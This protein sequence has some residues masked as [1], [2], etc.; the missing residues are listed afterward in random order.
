MADGSRNIGLAKV[1]TGWTGTLSVQVGATLVPITPSE[2]TSAIELAMRVDIVLSALGAQPVGVRADG[3]VLSWSAG[4]SFTL[5]ATGV[6]QSRL[7][8]AASTTGTTVTGAGAHADGFYP[9]QG[10]LVR[11]P[12]FA[13][14]TASPMSDGSAAGNPLPMVATVSIEAHD[15]LSN[16]WTLE[17]DFSSDQLWDLWAGGGYRGRMRI[18]SVKRNRLGKD[19]RSARLLMQGESI[20]ERGPA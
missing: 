10:M 7:N 14:S 15:T 11:S 2:P 3:G 9:A 13:S 8:V 6:I 16:L 17:D 12:L 19:A 20:F 4:V 18:N 5:A 1:L